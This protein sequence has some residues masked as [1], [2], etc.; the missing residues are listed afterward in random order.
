MVALDSLTA[1]HKRRK[2]D[3]AFRDEYGATQGHA[4]CGCPAARL[5]RSPA[6]MAVAVAVCNED[7]GGVVTARRNETLFKARPS[8]NFMKYGYFAKLSAKTPPPTLLSASDSLDS[9]VTAALP[10]HA[11]SSRRGPF[12]PS[13]PRRGPFSPSLPRRASF[14]SSH[15]NPQSESEPRPQSPPPFPLHSTVSD[16]AAVSSTSQVADCSVIIVLHYSA[17]RLSPV[18]ECRRPSQSS[19]VPSVA[20]ADPPCLTVQHLRLL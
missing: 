7:G 11:L 12:S 5:W 3:P 13:L 16:I 18:Q 10:H 17:I 19:L 4:A 6:S 2:E 14:S 20:A 1:D 8:S 15:T 9:T